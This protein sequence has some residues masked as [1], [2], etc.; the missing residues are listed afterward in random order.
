MRC[1][2]R[3]K[4]SHGRDAWVE[5]NGRHVC[6]YCGSLDS[7]TFVYLVS[8]ALEQ[9]EEAAV[10]IEDTDKSY[11]FYVNEFLLEGGTARWKFYTQH[12]QDLDEEERDDLGGD[13]L[14]AVTKFWEWM[15]QESEE[16][17]DSDDE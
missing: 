5:K 11:K 15:R 10:L 13:L 3:T 1:P 2:R 17:E 7:E 8:R 16:N 4:D 12:L 6:S 14:T 9:E